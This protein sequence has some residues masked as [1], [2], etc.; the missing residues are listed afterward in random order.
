MLYEEVFSKQALSPRID[1]AS[2][3]F[4]RIACIRSA[5]IGPRRQRLLTRRAGT[6]AWCGVDAMVKRQ[7]GIDFVGRG[8]QLEKLREIS[9]NDSI[10]ISTHW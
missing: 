9:A 7:S 1:R 10:G 8:G 5:I 2:R 6:N 4:P 3:N